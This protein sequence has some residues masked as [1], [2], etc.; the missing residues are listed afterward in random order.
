MQ[1]CRDA[2]ARDAKEF[3]AYF[4]EGNVQVGQQLCSH[5]A[6]RVRDCS[7]R[8]N[9]SFLFHGGK[10]SQ[11]A[12]HVIQQSM[13]HRPVSSQVFHLCCMSC[14]K[15]RCMDSHVVRWAKT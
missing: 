4:N 7:G 11:S 14:R 13:L 15:S 1:D 12:R 5:H 9:P 2:Q 8:E 6:C 10:R 3:A